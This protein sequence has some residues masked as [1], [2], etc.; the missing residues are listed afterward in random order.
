MGKCASFISRDKT[1]TKRRLGASLAYTEISLELGG[2]RVRVSSSFICDNN[3]ETN[4]NQEPLS[5]HLNISGTI[6]ARRIRVR[7]LDFF[8][9]EHMN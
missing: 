1:W 6:G 8:L 4:V 7:L 9:M 3:L 2:K 5:I